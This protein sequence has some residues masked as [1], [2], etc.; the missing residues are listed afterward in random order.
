M[1][2][3]LKSIGI[4]LAN[5]KANPLHTFLSTLG[6]IIG[7]ASLVAILALG[8]GLEQTGRE[9]LANTTSLNMVTITS[10]AYKTVDDIR[11]P[12]TN[13]PVFGLSDIRALGH[14]VSGR[15]LVD[16]A[17]NEAAEVTFQDSTWAVYVQ[18]GL[19]SRM[20]FTKDSL[21]WGRFI[22]ADEVDSDARSV[23][24]NHVLA[25]KWNTDDGL[26]N[27]T[28][29]LYGEEFE[30][31]GV[32]GNSTEEAPQ[33]FIPI[34]T[35]QQVNQGNPRMVIKVDKAEEIPNLNEELKGWLDDRFDVGNE[36]F[37]VISSQ[38]RVQQFAQGILLFKIIMGAITGISVLVG[39]IGVMNVLLISVTERTREIGIRKA[40]GA[41]KK[42][43]I[44]QFMAE[45]ITIAFI[46]SILGWILG[47]IGIFIFVPIVNSFVKAQFAAAIS[48]NSVLVIL[49]ISVIVGLLFGTY[50][51]WRAARLNPIDAMRHE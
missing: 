6:I 46:G 30:I 19:E 1:Q 39:G 27:K 51:A 7:V 35:F 49:V 44:L 17:R 5:I 42:D 8:D 29:K 37:S 18:G 14:K 20:E 47:M 48:I 2:Q 4:A 45:S 3:F 11:V 31:V 43:I 50:P 10:N 26:I 12:I 23:V 33:L 28:L 32:L 24:I 38:Y 25:E 36:A 34:S 21:Q 15:A 9:Q 16:M 22:T 40:T 13:R 41:K